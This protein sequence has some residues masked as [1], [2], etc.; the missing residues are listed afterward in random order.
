[1]SGTI[2]INNWLHPF[3]DRQRMTLASSQA[4]EVSAFD[5]DRRNRG[6][7]LPVKAG[8]GGRAVSGSTDQGRMMNYFIFD[9]NESLGH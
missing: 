6:G 8:K 5:Y 2:L 4:D 9:R 3:Y 7:G 1:L